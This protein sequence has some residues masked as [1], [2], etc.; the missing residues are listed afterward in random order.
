MGKHGR[1]RPRIAG[2]VEMLIRKIEYE[3]SNHH[4][5]CDSHDPNY[6]GRNLIIS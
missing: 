1:C 5:H 2:V 4:G 6:D 3:E